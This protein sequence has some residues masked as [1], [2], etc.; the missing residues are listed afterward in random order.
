M[1]EYVITDGS[2]WI[3]RDRK[4]KYVP[5]SCESLADRF[6]NK[7]VNQIFN[8]QLPK[9]LKTTF[10]VGKADEAPS[11]VKQIT[12]EEVHNNTEKVMFSE[13]IQRWLNKIEDL[14]GLASEANNR[15]EVL[16]NELSLVDRELCDILHYIEFCNLNAAQ[17]WK[18]SKMIKERRI[19]RRSI[20]NELN[21]IDIILGK[22]ISE[23]MVDEINKAVQ[24]MDKRTYEPRILNELFDF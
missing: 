15:K 16:N 5:T 23:T 8:N 6:S 4:G 3:M 18:A 21:V 1:A 19:K 2:R 22:R 11:N 14:N 12:I 20:K 9:A 10:H 24:G 13:N 7:L 17:G